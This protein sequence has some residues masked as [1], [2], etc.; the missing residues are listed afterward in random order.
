MRYESGSMRGRKALIVSTA[1]SSEQACG[2]NGRDGDM[3]LMLWPIM[4]ALHYIGF[5]VLQPYL[6]HGVR[7]GLAENEMML[8]RDQLAQRL[9]DYRAELD[10]WE[11]WPSVPFNSS[12]DFTEQLTLKPGAPVYSPFVRHAE[13]LGECANAIWSPRRDAVGN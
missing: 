2:A 12:E 10:R 3:R 5:E 4:N 13:H 9:L 6:I 7:G 11:D 1:G 8:Q